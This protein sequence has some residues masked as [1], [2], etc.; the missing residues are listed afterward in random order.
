MWTQA[1]QG[2][3]ATSLVAA[4]AVGALVAGALLVARRREGWAFVATALAIAAT[5]AALFGTLFPA[6]LPSLL[7]PAFDLTVTDAASR[8]YTLELLTWIGAFFLPLVLL[9]QS[10]SYWVFRRRVTR[11]HVS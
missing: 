8:P 5:T 7:D 4:C 6:V 11:A 1:D 9:Y 3:P 10:W 2:S